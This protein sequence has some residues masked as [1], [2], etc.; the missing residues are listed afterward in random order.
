MDRPLRGAQHQ[1]PNFKRQT[2][3]GWALRAA[4]GSQVKRGAPDRLLF[5]VWC[6]ALCPAQSA[7]RTEQVALQPQLLLT[8]KVE[9]WT[10]N[11]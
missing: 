11:V 7:Y 9:S 6:L 8:L 1:R 10:L 2:P 5:S 4:F 3:N